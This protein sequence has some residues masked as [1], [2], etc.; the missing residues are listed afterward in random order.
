MSKTP[1]SAN[2][3]LNDNF[4]QTGKFVRENQ[5]SLLFI[6]SAIV[7]MIIIYVIYQKLYIAPREERATNQMYVAQEFWSKKDWE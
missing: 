3:A 7:A 4:G 2:I 6:G 1:E 5:K